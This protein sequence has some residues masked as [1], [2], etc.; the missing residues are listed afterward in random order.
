MGRHRP[1]YRKKLVNCLWRCMKNHP[2]PVNEPKCRICGEDSPLKGLN[3]G[4]Q[5][6]WPT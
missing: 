1:K 2:N 4:G 6:Q 5:R 3:Q